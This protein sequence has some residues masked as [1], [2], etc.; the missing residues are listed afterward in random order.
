MLPLDTSNNNSRPEETKASGKVVHAEDRFEE[1]KTKDHHNNTFSNLD[2]LHKLVSSD[3][4]ADDSLASMEGVSEKTQNTKEKT[5]LDIKTILRDKIPEVGLALAS[6]M[7]LIAGFAKAT[8]TIPKSITNFFDKHA[9]NASKT[10]NLWNY[11][12]KGATALMNGRSWDGIGRLA[13]IIPTFASLEN[14]FLFSGVSS[15]IT[16]MEQGHI[17]KVKESNNLLEDFVNNSKAFVEKIKEVYQHGLGKDRLI[18]REQKIEEKHKGTMFVSAFGNF[19]GAVLGM[20]SPDKNSKLRK[21]AAVIRNVGGLGCDWGKFFHPEPNN[22]YSAIAYLGVSVLDVVQTFTPEPFATVLSHFGLT[23]NN[24][25][26]YFY[27]NTSKAR[28][29]GTYKKVAQETNTTKVQRSASFDNARPVYTAPSKAL[30][31]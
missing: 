25:A 16:M 11:V 27:V 10:A 29:E 9:L 20:L 17:D 2:R 12:A 14:F 23:I 8:Q 5:P 28:D 15:G 19:F 1:K 30:V 18:L 3:S 31:A 22:R 7:H 13:Y 4:S 21:I 26:N 6:G 24:L